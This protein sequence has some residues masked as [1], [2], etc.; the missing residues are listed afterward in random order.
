[1][2]IQNTMKALSDPI[3][4][5]ILTMLKAGRLSAGEIADNFPVSGAAISKHLS[6]LKDADLIRDAREGK[7][8]LYELNASVLEEVMLW[9]AGLKGEEK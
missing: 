6:V 2:G 8:I 3:R 4:R 5:E 9:M 1:M 7:Y